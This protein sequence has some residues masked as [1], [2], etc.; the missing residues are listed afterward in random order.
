ME[1]LIKLSGSQVSEIL[2]LLKD[3]SNKNKL[4]DLWINQV[5]SSY[6][7]YGEYLCMFYDDNQFEYFLSHE[8]EQLNFG[9]ELQSALIDFEQTLSDYDENLQEGMEWEHEKILQDPEFDKVI[10]KAGIAVKLWREDKE[11]KK[12]IV[13][14]WEDPPKEY[15]TAEQLKPKKTFWEK[16]FGW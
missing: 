5:L 1:R 16:L 3:Y 9:K 12:Y 7:S 2:Y 4:T 13:P 8:M 10:E 6:L 15:L 11:A 14:H